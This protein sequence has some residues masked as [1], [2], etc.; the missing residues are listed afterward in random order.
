L[1]RED[2]AI[3]AMALGALFVGGGLV[4]WLSFCAH[5]GWSMVG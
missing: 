5:L 4:A 3:V 1:T 2:W